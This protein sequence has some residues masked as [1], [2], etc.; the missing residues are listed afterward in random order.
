MKVTK[1]E[2]ILLDYM[3]EQ[4]QNLLDFMRRNG[5]EDYQN[6]MITALIDKDDDKYNS[7]CVNATQME[8]CESVRVVSK[9]YDMVNE[10][11]NYKEWVRGEEN[12]RQD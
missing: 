11:S 2:K 1:R 3:Y 10:T 4:A 7:I 9:Q 12:G 6:T 8:H 5:Y